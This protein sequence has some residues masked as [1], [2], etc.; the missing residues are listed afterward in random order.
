MYNLGM[1]RF[2]LDKS[3]IIKICFFQEIKHVFSSTKMN[4]IYQIVFITLLILNSGC[5]NA[6]PNQ[7][8]LAVLDD[9]LALL[10]YL[11][12]IEKDIST[13][14]KEL[15]AA[16]KDL[17]YKKENQVKIDES[18]HFKPGY[19]F[20]TEYSYPNTNIQLKFD[21]FNIAHTLGEGYKFTHDFINNIDQAIFKLK[22]IYFLDGT[23]QV[24]EQIKVV[25]TLVSEQLGDQ[26]WVL[27]GTKPIKSFDYS[28]ETHLNKEVSHEITGAGQCI[29]T[30]AGIIEVIHC[31]NGYIRI[32][33]SVPMRHLVKILVT[34]EQGHQLSTVNVES[35]DCYKKED[36]LAHIA[37]MEQAKAKLE[38]G[39]ITC[40]E[41]LKKFSTEKLNADLAAQADS[42]L[43]TQY[44]AADFKKA[45][46]VF[47][48]NVKQVKQVYE[49]NSADQLASRPEDFYEACSCV[50]AQNKK[51]ELYGLIGLD[52]NWIIAPRFLELK[53]QWGT[54]GFF[55]GLTENDEKRVEYRFDKE[56]KTLIKT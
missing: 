13:D 45:H 12:N 25:D 18:Y 11:M 34:D 9:N 37:H 38:K 35:K 47:W 46:L 48:D 16:F 17:R 19:P 26:T 21:R 49:R 22:K 6:Q 2:L 39:E 23:V 53:A 41:V 55:W 3:M 54:E 1:N 43:L 56:N 28:M 31:G 33:T 7:D 32:K 15:Q 42:L 50:I 20:I 52:G 24:G 4:K 30:S 44:F 10:D 5:S 29:Q 27:A 8:C 51:T 40:T 14:F 36:L